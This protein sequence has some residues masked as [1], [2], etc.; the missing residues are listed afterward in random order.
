M[1]LGKEGLLERRGE[2]VAP[3]KRRYWLV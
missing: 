1:P 3:L 2:K